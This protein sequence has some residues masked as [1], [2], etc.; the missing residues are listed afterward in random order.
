MRSVGAPATRL[1]L[2]IAVVAL[3]QASCLGTGRDEAEARPGAASAPAMATATARA[4]SRPEPTATATE[5]WSAWQET[6]DGL[7]LRHFRGG[8]DDAVPSLLLLRLDPQRHSLVVLAESDVPPGSLHAPHAARA[9]AI[10]AVNGGFFDA[11]GRAIG[12]VVANGRELSPVGRDGWGVLSIDDAGEVAIRRPAAVAAGESPA[13]ALQAGPRL[14]IDGVANDVKSARAR[15][16]FV[17]VDG[18]GR[19]VLGSTGLAAADMQ[20]LAHLLARSEREGG[21]GLDQAMAL[22]GGASAQLWLARPAAGEAPLT[23][24]GVG[25]ANLVAVVPRE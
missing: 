3:S 2:A 16:T 11:E 21:G 8:A 4:P 12:W 5:G 9:G 6:P 15:R 22:D 18:D 23:I 13:S 17:G 19:V 1:R 14:V 20:A 24:P 10:A 25:V 7:F